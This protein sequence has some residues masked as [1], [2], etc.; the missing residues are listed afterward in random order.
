MPK[1]S[2]KRLALKTD[3]K[4]RMATFI[5]HEKRTFDVNPSP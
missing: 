4:L 5:S 3:R 1:S 2:F